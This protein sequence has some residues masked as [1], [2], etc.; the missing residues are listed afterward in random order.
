VAADVLVRRLLVAAGLSAVLI[1]LG[2]VDGWPDPGRSLD[3]LT[4]PS[5]TTADAAAL[6]LLLC[7]LAVAILVVGSAVPMLTPLRR[8]WVTRARGRSLAVLAIGLTILGVGIARHQGGYRV[9]C[10]NVA[11]T[12]QAE[13]LV[14]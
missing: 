3:L 13:H 5:P 4:G 6:I 10:A 7:W 12:Q 9:C 2:V 14:R 1:T 8:V 11:T